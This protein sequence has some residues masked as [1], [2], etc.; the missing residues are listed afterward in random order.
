MK[1][2]NIAYKNKFTRNSNHAEKSFEA[3]RKSIFNKTINGNYR[4]DGKAF[5]QTDPTD[6]Y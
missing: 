2:E 1:G 3:S 6:S 5:I 4:M